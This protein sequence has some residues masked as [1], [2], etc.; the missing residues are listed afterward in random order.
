MKKEY[1]VDEIFYLGEK[2][3]I[4]AASIIFISIVLLMFGFL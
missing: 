2:I 3:L 4:I 1:T